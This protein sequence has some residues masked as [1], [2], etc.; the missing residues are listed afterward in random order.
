MI[1][2]G[3][4]G[5]VMF[6][7]KWLVSGGHFPWLAHSAV[8]LVPSYRNTADKSEFFRRISPQNPRLLS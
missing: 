3:S 5:T 4:E 8:I 2:E 7:A 6:D 1:G